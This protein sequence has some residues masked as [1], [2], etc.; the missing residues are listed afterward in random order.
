[1]DPFRAFTGRT[2]VLPLDD[3]DT[4]QIIPARFLKGTSRS[5]LGQGL[6]ADRRY[7]ADG[8]PRGDFPLDR[9]E[10]AG[11][12]VLVV[13][14]NF[15][16]GSSREHAVW[17]LLDHGIRAV[18]ATSFADIF[19]ANALKNG[20]LPAALP[21]EAHARLAA[22]AGASVTVDLV[23]QEVDLPDGTRAGF[24]VDPFARHCLLEGIDELAFLLGQE[25]AIAAY[26]STH[27]PGRSLGGRP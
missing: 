24:T 1:M 21:R 13:G 6:F 3:V 8:T 22:A 2:V 25:P 19:R 9:P 4:D 10:A 17:A 18:I 20:L 26:E 14:R 27:E 7:A 12:T 15:G 23:R 11:A 16:C 5:G